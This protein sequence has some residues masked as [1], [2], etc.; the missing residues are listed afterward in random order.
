[1]RRD[2]V[3]AR[4]GGIWRTYDKL[5]SPLAQGQSPRAKRIYAY[6]RGRRRP[7]GVRRDGE[8]EGDTQSKPSGGEEIAFSPDGKTVSRFA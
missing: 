3:P 6:R 5:L 4:S 8:L 7:M 1:M 2:D